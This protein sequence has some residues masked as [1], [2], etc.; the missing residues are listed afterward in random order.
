MHFATAPYK[1]RT[2]FAS[3][4]AFSSPKETATEFTRPASLWASACQNTS[5]IVRI[6]VELRMVPEFEEGDLRR[7]RGMSRPQDLDKL[8]DLLSLEPSHLPCRGLEK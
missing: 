8:Y 5:A 4:K 6:A 1:G 2:G 7:Y 3:D